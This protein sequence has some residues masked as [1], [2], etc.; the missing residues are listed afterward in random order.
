MTDAFLPD[1][2]LLRVSGADAESF[3]HNL[4]TTDVVGLPAGEARPGALLTP[5]GKILFDFLIWRDGDGC[6]VEDFGL[7][8]TLMLWAEARRLFVII[9]DD[10]LHDLTGLEMCLEAL[11][12]YAE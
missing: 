7:P 6:V 10:P 4:I 1:R 11:A 5:Q 2:A 12:L 3:L 9:T 8:E